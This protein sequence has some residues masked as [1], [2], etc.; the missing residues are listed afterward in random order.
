MHHAAAPGNRGAVLKGSV[1]RPYRPDSAGLDAYTYPVR[2]PVSQYG[3]SSAHPAAAAP[4]AGESGGEEE[5][6]ASPKKRRK[7]AG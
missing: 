3:K 2:A 6:A 5:S 4:A 7:R 1:Q